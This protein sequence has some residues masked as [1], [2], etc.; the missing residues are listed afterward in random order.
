MT[1]V[2]A[3]TSVF[4]NYANFS[5]RARRSEY[6]WFCLAW[7]IVSGVLSAFAQKSTIVMI[8]YV[9]VCLAVLVPS[10]AVCFRRLHDIGKSGWYLLFILIPLA[11]P[12]ILIVWYCKDSEPGANQYGPNPKGF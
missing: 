7:T 9:I 11:G 4:Q 6:W 8:L 1:I 2:E 10:L 5:G 3:V 12:I